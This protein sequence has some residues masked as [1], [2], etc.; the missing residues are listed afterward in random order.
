ML[1][2]FI[3]SFLFFI[4]FFYFIPDHFNDSRSYAAWIRSLGN[5][6]WTEVLGGKKDGMRGGEEEEED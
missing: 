3:F 5:P 4:Y 2:F 1:F 6:D